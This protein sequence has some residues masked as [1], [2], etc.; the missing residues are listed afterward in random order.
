MRRRGISQEVIQA[1]KVISVCEEGYEGIIPCGSSLGGRR[2]RKH[3]F[4]QSVVLPSYGPLKLNTLN[5]RLNSQP[6]IS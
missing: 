3:R 1:V 4:P 5:T 6:Q 2:G